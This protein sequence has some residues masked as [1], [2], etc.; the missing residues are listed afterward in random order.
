[1]A[2]EDSA[3]PHHAHRPAEDATGCRFSHSTTQDSN[4]NAA[5]RAREHP[6]RDAACWRASKW[7]AQSEAHHP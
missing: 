3:S 1:M 4:A 2:F 5:A 7:A 6:F